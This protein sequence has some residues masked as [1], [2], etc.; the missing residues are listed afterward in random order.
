M[1]TVLVVCH[2][3]NIDTPLR[4]SLAHLVKSCQVTIAGNGFQA[5]DELRAQTF[6]LVIIDSLIDGIDS[7]ELVE[8]IEYIDPGIPVILMLDHSHKALWGMARSLKAHPILRPFKPLTFLRLI[9]TQLHEHLE[10]YRELAETLKSIL[11]SLS[12]PT[13]APLA[14][15][16]DDAGQPL[17]AT[18]DDPPAILETLSALAV[19]KIKLNGHFPHHLSAQQQELLAN[20]PAEK[21]HDLY[22]ASV[23][24]KLY[25]ALLFP[26]AATHLTPADIWQWLEHSAK[27]IKRAFA[28]NTPL[29]ETDLLPDNPAPPDGQPAPENAR[30]RALI[31]LKL[32]ATEFQPRAE[33]A[34]QDVAPV[35]WQIIPDT[36][37]L[38]DRL[39]QFCRVS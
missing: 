19:N 13:Q 6:D 10:R 14:F 1:K 3:T 25:L 31:P 7:L 29:D 4:R 28:M 30:Q 39:E 22:L 37:N 20:T 26:A 5:F 8:A 36:P 16:V 32:G 9:D 15:L 33:P 27:E 23:I 38:V 24:D 2:Q 18:G 35:N 21:D 12:V 11:E 34:G 17:I